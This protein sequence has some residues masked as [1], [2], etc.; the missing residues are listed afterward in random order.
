MILIQ[1]LF[2][3]PD[4]FEQRSGDINQLYTPLDWVP[5]M[6]ACTLVQIWGDYC[7]QGS[8]WLSRSVWF[9]FSLEGLGR[10][11][12]RLVLLTGMVVV[13]V[14]VVGTPVF[15]QLALGGYLPKRCS[16]FAPPQLDRGTLVRRAQWKRKA[17]TVL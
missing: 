6:H 8:V 4:P 17:A 3:G 15:D 16:P 14:V 11:L 12:S 10:L 2:M 13:V 1:I 9:R 5:W 7:M